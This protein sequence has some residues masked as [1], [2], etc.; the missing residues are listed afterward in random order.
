VTVTDKSVACRSRPAAVASGVRTL[1]ILVDRTSIEVFANEGE[2]SLSAC[3][4]PTDDRLG[5]QCADGAVKLRSL[6]VF[7]LQSMWK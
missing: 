4:L 2:T 1:A 6:R 5:V 3:F 7:E